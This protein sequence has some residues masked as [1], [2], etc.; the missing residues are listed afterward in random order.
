LIVD[1]NIFN[2]LT[3][4]TILETA[5]LTG[6]CDSALNGQIAFDLV[7]AREEARNRDPC[8]CGHEE[9]GKNYKLIFMDCNMPVMD[10]FQSSKLIRSFLNGCGS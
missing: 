9:P 10:G 4:E 2:I 3:A 8:T 1:D 7:K 5:F 6:P